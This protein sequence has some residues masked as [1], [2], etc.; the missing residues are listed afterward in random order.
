MLPGPRAALASH[1]TVHACDVER[2]MLLSTAA[3]ELHIETFESLLSVVKVTVLAAVRSTNTKWHA[4]LW[5]GESCLDHSIALLN[6]AKRD[7]MDTVYYAGFVFS[8]CLH[9]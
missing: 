7:H 6:I 1:N 2:S 9:L 5:L 8:D 4:S 3:A